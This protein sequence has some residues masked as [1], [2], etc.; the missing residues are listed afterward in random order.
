MNESVGLWALR[1]QRV[2]G[3]TALHTALLRPGHESNRIAVLDQILSHDI[4]GAGA[5]VN[6]QDDME[7]SPLWYAVKAGFVGCARHLIRAGAL[8]SMGSMSCLHFG[9][10]GNVFFMFFHFFTIVHN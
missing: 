1:F 4:S 6:V 10:Q 7:R 3:R 2:G 9:F 8:V 5:L